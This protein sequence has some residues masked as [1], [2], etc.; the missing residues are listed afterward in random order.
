MAL[1]NTTKLEAVNTML[2]TIG[3]SGVNTLASGLDEAVAAVAT[4]DEVSRLVQA[5]G[6]AFNTEDNYPLP[7]T[8]DGKVPLPLNTLRLDGEGKKYVR[9]GGFLYDKVN[10]TEIFTDTVY[11]SI[12]FGLDFEDMPEI[13]RQYIM[14]RAARVFQTREVGSAD[15]H[16]FTRED[17]QKAWFSLNSFESDAADLT[18]FE[19]PDLQLM[20][21][22]S[23]TPFRDYTAGAIFDV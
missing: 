17:E 9:R 13:A 21:D 1:T 19:S 12:T 23:A 4:L 14:I 20:N 7:I 10:H 5:E 6:W 16:R 22:R 2:A 18:I 11:L 3:E 15:L 8:V